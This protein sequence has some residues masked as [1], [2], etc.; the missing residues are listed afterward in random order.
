[1][2]TPTT[3][4]APQRHLASRPTSVHSAS[5]I[6]AST[7]TKGGSTT[8]DGEK[9]YTHETINQVTKH[10]QNQCVLGELVPVRAN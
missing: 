5:S 10:E 8:T 6:Q 9:H 4:P 3:A 1:M 2:A 7:P